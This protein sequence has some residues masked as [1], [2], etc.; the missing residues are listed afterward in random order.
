MKFKRLT[1][2]L[3]A[4]LMLISLASCSASGQNDAASDKYFPGASEEMNGSGEQ[5]RQR[6]FGR[7]KRLVGLA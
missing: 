1:A 6:R 3:A 7:R 2:I 4:V 5:N